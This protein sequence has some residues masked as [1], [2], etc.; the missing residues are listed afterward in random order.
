[1]AAGADSDCMAAWPFETAITAVPAVSPGLNFR[2][3][4]KWPCAN[5]LTINSRKMYSTHFGDDIIK[6]AAPWIHYR[7]AADGSWPLLW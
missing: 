6:G 7:Y 3:S 2:T 5:Q 1:M 4:P